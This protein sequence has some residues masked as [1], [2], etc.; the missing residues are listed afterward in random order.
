[1]N[2]Y[3]RQVRVD[4]AVMQSNAWCA[5]R[6]RPAKTYPVYS[7]AMKALLLITALLTGCETS[8]VWFATHPDEQTVTVDG[9]SISVV[10]RGANK[11]DAFGGDDGMQ[12]STPLLK[13][14]Q[15]QAV[16]IVSKCKVTVAEFVP[17]TWILQT[18]VQCGYQ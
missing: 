12:T 9:Y 10:P 6:P 15:T 3:P 4:P 8:A 2:C 16:E 1:M 13:A 17:S 18:V 5:R 7:G 11:F 14:R